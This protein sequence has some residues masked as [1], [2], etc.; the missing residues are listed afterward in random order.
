M[1]IDKV[2]NNL[3]RKCVKRFPGTS[4]LANVSR[5]RYANLWMRGVILPGNKCER[6]WH[7]E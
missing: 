5:D 2:N 7:G 3:S 4:A 1:K 6:L